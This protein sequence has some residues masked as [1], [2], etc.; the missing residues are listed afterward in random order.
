MILVAILII[1]GEIMA[2]NAEVT[3]ILPH[4]PLKKVGKGYMHTEHNSL[5]F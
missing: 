3:N 4:L 5:K 2:P 1:K